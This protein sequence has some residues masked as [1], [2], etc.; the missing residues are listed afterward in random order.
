M[1]VAEHHG[2]LFKLMGDVMLVEY[3]SVVDVSSV[4]PAANQPGK[5]TLV[6]RMRA[7]LW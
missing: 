5:W 3:A 2:R 7:V 1:R 6:A 4:R